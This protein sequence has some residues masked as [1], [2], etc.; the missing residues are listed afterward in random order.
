MKH[1]VAEFVAGF[2]VVTADI[3]NLL[4]DQAISP[5]VF[6]QVSYMSPFCPSVQVF[7][8]PW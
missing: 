3:R 1:V 2:I 5:P 8:T 7:F 6:I 4:L